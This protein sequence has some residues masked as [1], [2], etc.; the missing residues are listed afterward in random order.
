MKAHVGQIPLF[1]NDEVRP[2]VSHCSTL[3]VHEV[4]CN[5]NA[6]YNHNACLKHLLHRSM[7][8]LQKA[9]L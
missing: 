4:I 7:A 6:R 2:F 3:V 9:K 5:C 1:Y 8:E